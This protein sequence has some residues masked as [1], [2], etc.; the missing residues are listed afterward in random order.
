MIPFCDLNSAHSEI[1][2]LL[3]ASVRKAIERSSFVLGDELLAFEKEFASYT[4]TKHCIGVGNGLDA[5]TLTLKA[6]GIGA[7]DE[8]IVPSQTFIAT[9]LAVTET[10]AT[11]IPVDID[12]YTDLIDY[13]LIEDKLTENTKAVIPVHLYGQ[14][15]D[16]DALR[17]VI[18]SRKHIFILED[19]AQAHG[20][21]YNSKLAGNMG[22]AA[23]FSFYP[24][25]NLGCLGDGGAVTTNDDGLAARLR[26]LRNYG[27]GQR[28]HHSLCGTNSRLDEVQAAL[29]RI[30]LKHLDKWNNSRITIA[31]LYNRELS[32]LPGLQL[33][34]LDV[35]GRHVYHLY[36]VKTIR[37]DSLIKHLENDKIQALIH[38]PLAPHQQECY[39]NFNL[40]NDSLPIGSKSASS[41]LSLPMWPGM[42]LSDVSAVIDSV[43]SF[44]RS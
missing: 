20:A 19:A 34:S 18:G 21:T 17:S 29:L 1:S 32:G 24:T 16:I 28:Y 44:F 31:T 30:K 36:V 10:G 27:S 33:P 5:L 9:W 35:T 42:P 15:V 43:K 41:C 25:K 8:V 26:L 12:E 2:D 3:Y 38:Y 13:R 11:P 23:A 22:D 7:G 37:R 6:K 14:L 4:G 39:L 40:S